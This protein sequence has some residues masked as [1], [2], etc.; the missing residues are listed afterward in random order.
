MQDA[1]KLGGIFKQPTVS[2][3]FTKPLIEPSNIFKWGGKGYKPNASTNP[4]ISE[5]PDFLK[6][7]DGDLSGRTRSID[8]L[9]K[10]PGLND[11]AQQAIGNYGQ[12]ASRMNTS[13]INAR[14][15]GPSAPD[16][17]RVTGVSASPS[18]RAVT[19]SGYTMP[20][21]SSSAGSV[22]RQG[23]GLL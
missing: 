17:G 6:V 14:A 10:L 8:S 9:V 13:T 20:S 7:Q 5:K 4:V 2:P 1:K 19:N 21:A 12:R 22:W 16:L 3:I 11:V 23:F 18:Y 15:W